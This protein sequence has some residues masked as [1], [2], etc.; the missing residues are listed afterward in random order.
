MLRTGSLTVNTI[1][2]YSFI[3]PSG[4]FKHFFRVCLVLLTDS[5]ICRCLATSWSNALLILYEVRQIDM[6]YYALVSCLDYPA[7]Y[8]AMC[9]TLVI[10]YTRILCCLMVDALRLIPAPYPLVPLPVQG[11][12]LIEYLFWPA[13]VLST[14]V[15]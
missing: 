15:L 2:A 6:L 1:L 4:S 11:V 9:V 14:T 12:A 7:T 3:S 8:F 10:S 5:D 13:P